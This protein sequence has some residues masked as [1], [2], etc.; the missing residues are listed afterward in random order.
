M[1]KLEYLI[2]GTPRSGTAYMARLLTEAGKPCG[3][4]SIFGLGGEVFA[5][6]RLTSLHN[7]TAK[8]FQFNKQDFVR[9]NKSEYITT[10]HC[11]IER[12]F[13]NISI[14]DNYLDDIL[15]ITAD[16]SFMSAPFL[17]AQYLADTKIIHVI[18]NP[19][20]VINSL[21]NYC[22]F[23]HDRSIENQNPFEHFF[24]PY[25]RR[26]QKLNP[27]ERACLFW[28]DWN[29]M[30]ID[31]DRIAYTHR[32]EDSVDS[33]LEFL[34]S[35]KRNIYVD[36]PFNSGGIELL[37]RHRFS[38]RNVSLDIGIELMNFANGSGYD[39]SKCLLD[40]GEAILN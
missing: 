21:V 7:G 5:K 18:R 39:I 15:S 35:E 29:K 23:F 17:R 6:Q 31:S 33:L 16:S 25:L 4:E 28:I 1:R 3:H 10:S 2:V 12:K 26:P 9:R 22:G 11:S 34:G 36:I 20:L 37:K 8:S 27:Y 32:I 38:L 14:I 30:I 13:G 24:A 19:L 40:N